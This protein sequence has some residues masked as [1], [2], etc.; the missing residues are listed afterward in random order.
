LVCPYTLSY[1]LAGE[2]EMQLSKDGRIITLEIEDTDLPF[3]MDEKMGIDAIF[4][5]MKAMVENPLL[6]KMFVSAIPS[7]M[8]QDIMQDFREK[9]ELTD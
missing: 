5:G 2:G 6:R 8:I 1:F 9:W 4:T 3:G 7:S